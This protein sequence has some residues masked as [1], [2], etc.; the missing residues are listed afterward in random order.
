MEEYRCLNLSLWVADGSDG[1]FLTADW[2]VEGGSCW[3]VVLSG[4]R[5][6]CWGVGG[7]YNMAD[8]SLCRETNG[9]WG[10]GS[11]GPD[12]FG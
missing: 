6:Q 3:L 11:L 10:G 4:C 5:I 2:L 9:G 1:S 12:T 8:K 7:K